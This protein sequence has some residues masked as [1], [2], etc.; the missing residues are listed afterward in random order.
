MF[1]SDVSIADLMVL[2]LSYWG[3]QNGV[4]ERLAKVALRALN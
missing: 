4:P 2:M 1:R 3:Q